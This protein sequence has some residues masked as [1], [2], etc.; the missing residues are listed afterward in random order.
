MHYLN[1]RAA[2]LLIAAAL[3]LSLV[4]APA[5]IVRHRVEDLRGEAVEPP[6]NVLTDEQAMQQVVDAA[7]QFVRVGRLGHPTGSYLLQSCEGADNEPPY[8]GSV[9][10]TFDV[11]SI[12]RTSGYFG[13][14]IRDMTARGWT[15]GMP[16]KRYPGGKT[17]AKQRVTALIYRNPETPGRG[18]LRIYGEC[19]NLTD[20]RMDTA[21]F[22]DVTARLAG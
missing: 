17:L 10:V 9:Y 14:I 5:F 19:G 21:G 7:R 16:S 12:A 2:R 1:S 4:L 3:L 20:H 13:E 6:E 18:V 22:L 15:E 11:P 8:Q